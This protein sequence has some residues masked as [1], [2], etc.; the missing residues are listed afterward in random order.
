MYLQ[1]NTNAESI[2][3]EVLRIMQKEK[4]SENDMTKKFYQVRRNLWI[5]IKNNGKPRDGF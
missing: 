2:T 5:V 3:K 1:Y 4:Q